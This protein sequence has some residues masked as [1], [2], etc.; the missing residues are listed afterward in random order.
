MQDQIELVNGK[1]I[2]KGKREVKPSGTKVLKEYPEEVIALRDRVILGNQKLFDAWLK[3]K[4]L[5]H[6]TEQWSQQMDKWHGAQQKLHLLCQE[7]K[8]KGFD[9]CLYLDANGKKSKGCLKNP[10]GFW[11]QVCP[12]T[13][14]YWE[15][16]M[17][18][19]PS[20]GG[21]SG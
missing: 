9:V 21:R 6:D 3:I 14:P 5:A 2:A 8:Y 20:P 12:S 15:E 4:E 17:L 13:Y 16:E 18:N 11:C 19:L 7:L 10:D 1:F